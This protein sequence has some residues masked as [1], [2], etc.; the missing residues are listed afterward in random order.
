[1]RALASREEV[2]RAAT[3]FSLPLCDPVGDRS[4]VDAGDPLLAFEDV[5]VTA[6]GLGRDAVAF[7]EFGHGDAAL[8]QDL[9]GDD[10]LPLWRVHVPSI[11]GNVWE[12]NGYMVM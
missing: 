4:A 8:V 1:M 7:G 6:D 12:V 3:V 5:Q 10:V 2:V 11:C 9:P